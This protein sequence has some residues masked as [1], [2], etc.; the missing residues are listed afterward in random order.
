MT[1]SSETRHPTQRRPFQLAMVRR[2]I[3]S[4][5]YRQAALRVCRVSWKRLSSCYGY[6]CRL[7]LVRA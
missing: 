2:F 6:R 4:S 3:I 1:P 7:Y 5:L